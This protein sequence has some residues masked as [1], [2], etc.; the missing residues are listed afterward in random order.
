M[1]GFKKHRGH[2]FFKAGDF[3]NISISEILQFVNSE[4]LLN[5]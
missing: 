2:H 5:A 1:G 3:A 4:G